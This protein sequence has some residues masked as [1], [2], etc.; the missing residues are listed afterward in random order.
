MTTLYNRRLQDI[1]IFMFKIKHGM[2]SSS[3]TEPFK[4]SHTNYNLRNVD[5]R[6]ECFNTAT[7]VTLKNASERPTLPR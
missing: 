1:A 5:F 4:T 7:M 2:L 3:V 6:Q